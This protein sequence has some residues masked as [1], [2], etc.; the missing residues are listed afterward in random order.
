MLFLLVSSLA[1]QGVSLRTSG[2]SLFQYDLWQRLCAERKR[3][4]AVFGT[5]SGPPPTQLM[6]V[7]FKQ[8]SSVAAEEEGGMGSPQY[9]SPHSLSQ[10]QSI[11]S[12]SQLLCSS[13]MSSLGFP[14][15]SSLD[16]PVVGST[17]S[18]HPSRSHLQSYSFNNSSHLAC[19]HLSCIGSSPG[20]SMPSLGSLVLSS[21]GSSLLSAFAD[22][23]PTVGNIAVYGNSA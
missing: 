3:A 10:S 12:S 20:F 14:A 13:A 9:H 11:N 23:Q 17:A 4:C 15:V 22:L 18:Y 7:H 5:T 1:L 2:A 21:R 19:S 6:G 16:S 8:P